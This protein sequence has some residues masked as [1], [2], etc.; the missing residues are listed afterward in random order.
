A[1]TITIDLTLD[2]DS[3]KEDISK[4]ASTPTIKKIRVLDYFSADLDKS[5]DSPLPAVQPFSERS[6][7]PTISKA[8]AAFDA[9]HQLDI[10]SKSGQTN[11]DSL[12]V[13]ATGSPYLICSDSD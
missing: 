6:F 13:E 5:Y 7:S 12:S 11:T 10:A 3:D 8:R 9:L 2:E 1:E 4:E